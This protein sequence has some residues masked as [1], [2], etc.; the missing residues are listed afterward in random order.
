MGTMLTRRERLA[1]NI[2]SAESILGMVP[3]R[4][5]NTNPR[6]RVHLAQLQKA[7]PDMMIPFPIS[8]RGSIAEAVLEGTPVWRIKRSAA[9]KAAK[10]VRAVAGY[11]L[12]K[13]EGE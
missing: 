5:I 11:I 6:H 8:Q 7:Y 13:L 2:I 12:A 3:N 9:R 10:E 4:V 1:L